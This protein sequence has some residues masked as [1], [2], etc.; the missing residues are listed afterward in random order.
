MN[1][2]ES[3]FFSKSNMSNIYTK[4]IEKLNLNNLSAQHKK[5]ISDLVINNMKQIYKNIDTT[6]IN[7]TNI[8][9]IFNQFNTHSFNLSLKELQQKMQKTAD[10]K[11]DPS[12]LKFERDFKS[13]PQKE[14]KIQDRSQSMMG[15]NSHSLLGPNAQFMNQS[16]Q[17][18]LLANQFDPEIDS[19]FKPLINDNTS[20]PTFNNYNFNKDGPNVKKKLEDIIQSR[21]T[22][23]FISK[24]P[25]QTEVPDFLKSKPT[26]IRT[27][28]IDEKSNFNNSRE[29]N[30]KRELNNNTRKSNINTNESNTENNFLLSSNEDES[31]LM[32]LNNYDQMITN[33]G[34]YQEDTTSFQDRLKKLENDRSNVNIPIKDKVNFTSDHFEDTF[35]YDQ[36]PNI[37]PTIINEI[38]NKKINKDSDERQMRNTDERQMRNTDERQMRNTDERQMR[39]INERQ[40]RNTDERQM[41]NT[42]ERQMRNPDERQMRNT[43]ERQ[44]RNTDERQMRNTDERQMRNTDERQMRNPDERQMRNPDEN[45]NNIVNITKR[46]TVNEKQE[47]IKIFEELKLL[48]T[49]LG[50]ELKNTKKSLNLLVE[51]KKNFI[52][53]KNY[54]FEE[55]KL[56]IE[57]KKLF[58]ENKYKINDSINLEKAKNEIA[59]EFNKLKL[60][61]IE[62]E[63]ILLLIDKKEE[64]QKIRDIELQEKELEYINLINN[65]NKISK[66]KNFILEIS[67]QNNSSYYTYNFDKIDN[68]I[69]IKLNSYSIPTITYNIEEDKN[70]IFEL[71][72]DDERKE[73]IISTGKYEIDKLLEVLNNNNFNLVFELEQSSQFVKCKCDKKF[74]IIHSSLSF[75]NLGFTEDSHSKNEYIANKL[76]DLRIDNKIYLYLNNID[77]STPYAVL[78]PDGL[79]NAEIKLDNP[80]SLDKIDILFKDYKGRLCNFYNLEHNL[81]LNLEILD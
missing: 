39:N 27:P 3:T 54:L 75:N 36:I 69:S 70:N 23:V 35:N 59:E 61:K 68:I 10:I 2:I 63:N 47:F 72:I 8:K 78:I 44:M 80:I 9:G 4:L 48:N 33:D 14:I 53:E 16:K 26:S 21:D 58:I 77:N 28:D 32:S 17:T 79:P 37:Q 46:L 12:K 73:I 66:I 57:E 20:E 42:D 55:K 49:K 1:N 22:E 19:L 64:D 29:L 43:D 15:S 11:S 56:F 50:D 25:I 62:N 7:Q 34:D 24:K 31:E 71:E 45:N 13:N 65:Y 67:S 30:N 38:K 6:K 5:Y 18:Q 51:E 60:L 40:M 74:N 76:F 52:E 81:S 41:R